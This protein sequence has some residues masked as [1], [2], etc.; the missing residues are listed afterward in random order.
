M[1]SD[2]FLCKI[3]TFIIQENYDDVYFPSLN[4]TKPGKNYPEDYQERSYLFN[5]FLLSLQLC[6]CK[7]QCY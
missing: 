1:Y 2:G 6:L 4:F 5:I 3:K 7:F